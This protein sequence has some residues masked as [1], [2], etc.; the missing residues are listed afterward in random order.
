MDSKNSLRLRQLREELGLTVDEFATKFSIAEKTQTSYENGNRN[1][2][3]DYVVKV[4]NEYNVT[5]DWLYGRVEYKN[6]SD[7]MVDI[8]LALDKIFKVG[9]KTINP[10]YE[11]RE[12]TLWIDRKFREYLAEIRELEDARYLNKQITDEIYSSSRRSIQGKYKEYFKELLGVS[13]SEIN[14]SK[15]INIEAVEDADILKYL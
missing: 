14:E 6:D 8:I 12:V 5:L 1:M 15:F 13:N 10:K 7:L 2:P 9:Y 11:Y 3:A 4:C